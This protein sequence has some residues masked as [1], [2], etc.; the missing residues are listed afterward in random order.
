MP[1]Q[2][3]RL[4]EGDPDPSDLPLEPPTYAD[5]PIEQ[6][7]IEDDF[8]GPPERALWQER[9]QLG[10]T[11][12]AYGFRHRVVAPMARLLDPIHEG[13]RHVNQTFERLVLKMGNPL[14]VK[15][16]LY[17]GFILLI[18]FYIHHTPRL[19]DPDMA[20]GLFSDHAADRQELYRN[21]RPLISRADMDENLHYFSQRARLA[22]T[23]NDLISAQYIQKWFKANGLQSVSMQEAPVFLNYPDGAPELVVGD[24]HAAGAEKGALEMPDYAFFPN[25][26]DRGFLVEKGM[27]YASKGARSDFDRLNAAKVEIKDKIVVIAPNL[28]LPRLEI[29]AYAHS[30][31]AAAAVF[32]SPKGATGDEIL[33]TNMGRTRMSFGNVLTPEYPLER[34]LSYAAKRGFIKQV[35]WNSLPL[36]PKI[37][38]IPISYNDGAKL[39]TKFDGQGAQF[40]DWDAH[41]DE[42]DNPLAHDASNTNDS[43]WSGK[44]DVKGRL[45]AKVSL[46][47]TQRVWNVMGLIE[48]NDQAGQA[49]IIGAARDSVGPDAVGLALGTTVLLELVRALTTLQR[50]LRWTPSRLI[51]FLLFDA[52]E[53]NAAG[54]TEW[55]ELQRE[56]LKEGAVVYF[57]INDI[58]SGDKLD[59]QAN[60]L[61]SEVIQD[62]LKGNHGLFDEK[63]YMDRYKDLHDNNFPFAYDLVGDRDSTPFINLVN[64]PV[65]EVKFVGDKTNIRGSLANNRD[66]LAKIDPEL[67]LHADAVNVLGLLVLRVA[68]EPM[69]PY[70][71]SMFANKL[72]YWRH[73]LED[74][75]KKMA[76]AVEFQPNWHFEAVDKGISSLESA[77]NIFTL[78]EREWRLY[79]A[80]VG[81][82]EPA[83]LRMLR[84]RWNN[85]LLSVNAR[86]VTTIEDGIR[87]GY[88]NILFGPSMTTLEAPDWKQDHG[89][90]V[91]PV[92]LDYAHQQEWG[93]TQEE[94]N[95]LGAFI[96]NAAQSLAG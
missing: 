53:Y 78:N 48:G 22:G 28:D 54:A 80:K 17:V 73:Q 71:L 6:F 30:L 12:V 57:D 37:P 88:R 43:V 50:Q 16:L 33:R 9:A 56:A 34:R 41:T 24:F 55:V 96:L 47:P 91:F 42:S 61:L 46:S 26:A 40:P 14:V 58:V 52:L 83:Q 27:V 7:E 59:V 18:V 19:Q 90:N 4:P 39:L 95:K 1:Q 35:S 85:I 31:G 23:A 29:L 79:M 51:Y 21:L 64:T 69:L 66:A 65:V 45:T 74:S 63:L 77:S 94:I 8:A 38:S 76:E 62:V 93:K 25:G 86:F 92:I 70:S 84:V 36:T 89:A 67:K 11:K 49:I 81:H 82:M 10:I 44:G 75:L 32:I 60:P 3:T 5:I 87:P 68:E 20:H 15:R 2:Y 72:K 13:Y